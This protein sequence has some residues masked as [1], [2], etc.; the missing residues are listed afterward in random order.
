[1]QC[2]FRGGQRICRGGS[3][4]EGRAA[5]LEDD[6]RIVHYYTAAE[7]HIVTLNERDDV[8]FSIGRAEIDCIAAKTTGCN[9]WLR[10]R[11]IDERSSLCKVVWLDKGGRVDSHVRRIGKIGVAVCK[12]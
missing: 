12:G 2:A 10:H 7:A 3:E 8:S 9:R 4:R 5:I 1:M 6:A 11:G